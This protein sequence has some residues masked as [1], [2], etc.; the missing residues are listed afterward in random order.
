[1][2]TIVI[3]AGGKSTRMG[4]DKG[5][6]PFLGT[7]L[8]KLLTDRFIPLADE[9]VVIT[10]NP[11]EYQFLGLPLHEDCI[12]DRGALGGLYTALKVAKFSR[13][14]VIAADMPF[15]STD[16]INS[17]L[18]IL[19]QTGAAAVIPST[20]GGLEPLH[21]VYNREICLPLI[22]NAIDRDLWKM[23]SWHHQAELKILTKQETRELISSDY[24]F[25]N[26]NTPEDFQKAEQIAFED[27]QAKFL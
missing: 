22:K 8:V 10:N 4:A 23:S 6:L 21:A 20:D 26:I 27:D 16:L 15:A 11:G 12:P 2:L 25:W 9:L 7:P 19:D 14:A 13:V 18:K 24:I 5:L 1:M 17:I 3:Q